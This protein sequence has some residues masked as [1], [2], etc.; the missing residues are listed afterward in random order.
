MSHIV[1][2]EIEIPST[3]SSFRGRS[4]IEP[5]GYSILSGNTDEDQNK[6]HSWMDKNAVRL[7]KLYHNSWI[8]TFQNPSTVWDQG[9]V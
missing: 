4:L 9:V 6:K 5:S 2:K 8:R 3:S 1:F 7:F